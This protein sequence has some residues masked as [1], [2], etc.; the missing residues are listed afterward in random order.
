MVKVN[1][2]YG[3]ILR[4]IETNDFRYYH[5]CVN[6]GRVLQRHVTISSKKMFERFVNRVYSDD[7]LESI[8]A[9]RPNTKFVVETITNVTL[10][11][12]K[13]SNRVGPIS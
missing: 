7:I 6:E 5:S 11:V 9:R 1:L 12:D 4:D 3:F 8:R 10:Y 2:S 13:I